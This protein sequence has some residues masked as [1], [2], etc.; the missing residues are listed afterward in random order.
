MTGCLAKPLY[1]TMQTRQ[2]AGLG[3]G[4]HQALQRL[5]GRLNQPV[6]IADEHM[7][8]VQACCVKGCLLSGGRKHQHIYGAPAIR[9]RLAGHRNRY[10]FPPPPHGSVGGQPP[11]FSLVFCWEVSSSL[12]FHV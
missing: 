9:L 1:G 10:P 7:D 6:Q 8:S 12:F 5:V 11:K 2:H 3:T 4:S